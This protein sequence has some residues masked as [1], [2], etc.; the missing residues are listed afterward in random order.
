MGISG[1]FNLPPEKGMKPEN[2]SLINRAAMD[3][4]EAQDAR[5]AQEIEKRVQIWM[6]LGRTEQEA[7]E[8]VDE[9]ES[10]KA[11]EIIKQF[12]QAA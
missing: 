10:R 9:E 5:R 8:L 7:R 11:A 2:V 4:N 6:K 3:E 12:D 1:S